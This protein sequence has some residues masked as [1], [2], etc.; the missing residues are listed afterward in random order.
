MEA[1]DHWRKKLADF[2]AP[3]PLPA[4]R[5]NRNAPGYAEQSF[6]L[7]EDQTSLLKLSAQRMGLTLNT[8]VQGAWGLLLA[9]HADTRHVMFGSTVSGR[10]SEFAGADTMVGMFVNTLPLRVEIDPAK[11]V[12][13]WLGSCSG[14]MPNCANTN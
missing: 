12:R 5:G 1:D 2:E 4:G 14:K 6:E 3:T 10:S 7:S 13:E 9:R 11:C 8:L